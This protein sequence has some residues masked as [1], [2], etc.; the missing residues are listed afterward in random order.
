M[1]KS[2][3]L[4]KAALVFR[5]LSFC[6]LAQ[7]LVACGDLAVFLSQP[8]T[9]K[10]SQGFESVEVGEDGYFRVSWDSPGSDP[11][12]SADYDLYLLKLPELPA[13]LKAQPSMRLTSEL[14]S[15]TA[16]SRE[17]SLSLKD[18]GTLLTNLKGMQT[19]IHQEKIDPKLF[20][21]FSIKG[22]SSKAAARN[23]MVS[24]K[25]NFTSPTLTRSSWNRDSAT[26]SWDY[27][28]GATSYDIFDSN[29]L[30][31]VLFTSESVSAELSFDKAAERKDYCVRSRRGALLSDECVPIQGVGKDWTVHI[32]E[33]SG[34]TAVN[35][36]YRAGDSLD[37]SVRFSNSV[38]LKPG[39]TTKLPFYIGSLANA[40]YLSGSGTDTLTFRYTVQA[41]DVSQGLLPVPQLIVT[42]TEGLVDSLGQAVD[43]SIYRFHYEQSTNVKIDADP[44]TVD[45][46]AD[47]SATSPITLAATS[48][49]ASTFSWSQVS[50]PGT[51]QFSAA[52]KATTEF[53]AAGDGVYVVRLTVEDD[54]GLS[55]QDDLQIIWDNNAPIVNVGTDRS[56][57]A[58][59]L[60]DA[61]TSGGSS[62]QWTQISGPGTI[63]F[64]T[65]TTEDS[66]VSA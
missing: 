14:V 47:R 40:S 33:I 23:G 49:G 62:Y 6:A 1:L 59:T 66:T 32:V 21:V 5:A 15:I 58:S 10:T 26:L 17:D 2:W 22:K 41:G 8:Q 35:D 19:Y 30:S 65:P 9:I 20:Y 45:V 4:P 61:T 39:A 42:P 31:K 36:Y 24:A 64:G 28:S 50:G 27:V 12:S 48:N 34:P 52:D 37:I 43:L 11:S 25:V 56:L 57:N 3:V 54:S 38:T 60:I 29:D 18:H 7:T 51:A 13:S 55:A 16:I 63:S 53:S 46:G 44:P